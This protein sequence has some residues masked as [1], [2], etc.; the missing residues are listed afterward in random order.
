[1]DEVR[2]PKFVPRADSSDY[3]SQNGLAEP[4]IVSQ[5]QGGIAGDAKVIPNDGLT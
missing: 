3:S 4:T 5:I 1:M 2:I